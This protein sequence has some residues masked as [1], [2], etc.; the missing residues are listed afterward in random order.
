VQA[1]ILL[2]LALVMGLA[3]L[4]LTAVFV[5]YQEAALRAILGRALLAEARS[6][7][8]LTDSLFP[9]TEWWSVASDGRVEPRDRGR[10]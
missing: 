6:P 3:T 2:G 4:V 10:G 9:G 1:E 5:A 7:R 8:T